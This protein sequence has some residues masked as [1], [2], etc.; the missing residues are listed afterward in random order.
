MKHFAYEFWLKPED[1]F[2]F[3]L[4]KNKGV[5]PVN[6]ITDPVNFEDTFGPGL[7]TLKVA[8]ID[9][10][11]Y[12]Y[13][14]IYIMAPTLINLSDTKQYNLLVFKKPF[15]PGIIEVGV[16]AY[17]GIGK[18]PASMYQDILD[19]RIDSLNK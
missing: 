11:R 15:S 10:D 1:K 12:V 5:I 19:H 16:V 3:C 14:C 7:D 8:D 18:H 17:P 6:Q 4:N 2:E 13:S 9:V